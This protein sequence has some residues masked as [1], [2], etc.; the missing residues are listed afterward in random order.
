LQ[1]VRFQDFFHRFH[2]TLDLWV[3]HEPERGQLFD[4][5]RQSTVSKGLLKLASLHSALLLRL[6][7]QFNTSSAP[8][9]L[10]TKPLQSEELS[11][12]PDMAVIFSVFSYFFVESVHLYYSSH[13]NNARI[14]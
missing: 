4:C 9:M 3:A 12:V 11:N 5:L 1:G 14:P 8:R 7:C 6:F 13:I 10:F 2:L